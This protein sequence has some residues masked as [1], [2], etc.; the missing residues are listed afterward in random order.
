MNAIGLFPGKFRFVPPE[1]PVGGRGREDGI[2]EAEG[3]DDGLGAEVEQLAAALPLG[4]PDPVVLL[5][6]PR[7]GDDVEGRRIGGG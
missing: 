3:P 1:M 2:G 4:V 6:G 5:L 7:P